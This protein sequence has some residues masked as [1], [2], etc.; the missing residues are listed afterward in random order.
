MPDTVLPGVLRCFVYLKQN[1]MKEQPSRG[2]AHY[3]ANVS[4]AAHAA[5]TSSRKITLKMGLYLYI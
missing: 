4:L 3:S 5:R 2:K 1:F